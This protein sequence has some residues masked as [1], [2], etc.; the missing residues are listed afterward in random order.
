M[1]TKPRID[2]SGCSASGTLGDL[3]RA[4]ASKARVS[5]TE[6]IALV[7]AIANGNQAALQALYQRTH[8]LVFTLAMRINNSRET[9]EEVTLDVFHDVWEGAGKYDANVGT[10]LA[11]IMNQARSRAIDRMRFDHR[12]KRLERSVEHPDGAPEHGDDA[13]A[14]IERAKRIRNALIDLTRDEREAIEAA[15]FADVT[16]ND[17]AIRL[18]QP[19]G[20]IKT[21]I[22]SGL[23]KL[24]LALGSERIG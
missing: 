2:G 9:A 16:Y 10:V 20:T 22:R 12:K 8:R 5:E 7:E 14:T 19:L 23:A 24:R 15:F 1:T 4:D 11:W 6:W 17:V 13:L 21:R 3:L 18:K